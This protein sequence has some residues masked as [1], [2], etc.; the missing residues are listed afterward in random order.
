[1]AELT[2]ES[3]E[4][5]YKRFAAPMTMSEIAAELDRMDPKEAEEYNLIFCYDIF[6]DFCYN[7]L[8]YQKEDLAYFRSLKKYKAF[9]QR[10]KLLSNVDFF[11]A[12]IAFLESRKKDVE[13]YLHKYIQTFAGDPV[14]Y[15][16]ADISGGILFAFKNAYPGFWSMVKAEIAAIPH[17]DIATELCDVI[18]AF[19]NAKSNADALE[20]L[21]SAYQ[22]RP[23]SN[24]INELLGV[25]YYDDKQYGSAIAAFERLY[26]EEAGNYK[27]ALHTQDNICFYLAYANSKQKDWKS[28]IRYYEKAVEIFPACPYAANNLGHAYYHERQYE[29]AYAILKRCI[30]EKLEQDIAYPVANFARVLLAMGRYAEA[31]QFLK[32][33]PARVPKALREKIQAA[34]NKNMTKATRAPSPDIKDEK[35]EQAEP[36][37]KPLIARKGVQFQSEKLL[38]DELTMRMEAGVEVFGL[39]LKIY[40]RRGEYGR[41]YIFPKGRLDIL[42]EDN[43]GDLYIIELKKDSGYDDAYQQTVEYIEWIQKHKARGRKVYGIICLNDPGKALI[44]AVRKDDRVKLFEYHISYDE[45]K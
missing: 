27:A 3:I 5:F 2:N 40:R 37:A 4:K 12:Y 26:D 15:R 25:V 22:R 45:I 28:A 7:C 9:K 19:Y 31:K 11:H 8:R 36:A 34:P 23:D 21:T 20:V 10:C 41:Q 6:W 32:T 1:M 13:S 14:P 29:K 30:E 38:E 44:E 35:E 17:E 42:A 18:D 43:N 39:P 24:V 33:A 16:E